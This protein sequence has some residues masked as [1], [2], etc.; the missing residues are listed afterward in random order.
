MPDGLGSSMAGKQAS[1]V[2]GVAVFATDDVVP[3]D[4]AA[5]HAV[6]DEHGNRGAAR[7]HEAMIVEVG[8]SRQGGLVLNPNGK[9]EM[10]FEEVGVSNVSPAFQPINRPIGRRVRGVTW[11]RDPQPQ[12]LEAHNLG[13]RG[14]LLQPHADKFG[15]VLRMRAGERLGMPC[16]HLS[17]KVDED[18]LDPTGMS[19]RPCGVAGLAAERQGHRRAAPAGDVVV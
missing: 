5:A 4:D 3:I 7:Q 16:E 9:I 17:R 8:Q 10:V 1:D 11:D 19:H 6:T 12:E 14:K 2:P 18:E 13:R 15:E